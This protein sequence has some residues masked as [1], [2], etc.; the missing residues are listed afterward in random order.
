MA[1][2]VNPYQKRP[3]LAAQVARKSVQMG[4][5]SQ[6]RLT[7]QQRTHKLQ[8]SSHKK[9][10]GDQLTLFGGQVF[11]PVKHCVV[12]KAKAIGAAVPHRGHDQR[13]PMNRKTKGITNPQV[14][15][16]QQQDQKLKAHFAAPSK[17]TEKMSSNN[18]TT[19]S[20]QQF[21]AKRPA[22]NLAAPSGT[23]T[24]NCSNISNDNNAN[25]LVTPEDLC[26]G[27]TATLE[28]SDFCK[29][30]GRFRAP[31][32]MSAIAAIVVD[33]VINSKK[34]NQF[35]DCFDG[36]TTVVPASENM[37]SSPGCHSIVG[38][39]LLLVDWKR[40]FG[41]DVV[42]PH[43]Q[44]EYLKTTRTN[45][46]R[47]KILFPVFG[48]SGPPAW[49]MVQHYKCPSASCKAAFAANDGIILCNLPAYAAASYPVESKYALSK[50]SHVARS[51]TDVFD[52][53]MTTCGN[54][55]LCS[56]LLYN[57]VNRAYMERVT[58]CCSYNSMK[59]QNDKSA[60][61]H[62][63]KEGE[64]ISTHPP[65]GDLIRDAYDEAS[66]SPFTRWKISDHDRHTREIQ[67]VGCRLSCA[68][69]HTH[70]V[71]KNCYGRSRIGATALWDIGT[72]TGEIASAVLVPTTATADL[73]HAA[74]QVTRRPNFNPSAICSDRWPTKEDYWAVLL[75]KEVTGRLGLFHFIK[76]ILRT[77][78]KRHI[79]YYRALN[80]LLDAICYY[81]Q[82]DYDQL[83]GALKAGTIGGG[84]KHTD[85]DIADL[86]MTKHFRKRYGKHL[87]K[88]IRPA[89]V[90]CE[91]LN[92]WFVQ[93]KVTASEGA[94]PPLGRTDPITNEP[95]FTQDTKPAVDNCKLKAQHLQDPLP[96]QQMHSAIE[97]VENSAHGLTQHASHRGESNL[98][99]FHLMLAH[100][101][102]NGM[103]ESLADNLNLTG[104][105]RHNLSIRHKM[106]LMTDETTIRQRSKMPSAWEDVVSYCNHSELIYVNEL[107]KEA[108]YQEVPFPVVESLVPDTGERFFSECL[109][110]IKNQRPPHDEQDLCLCH[111]CYG[112]RPVS[113][114]NKKHAPAV[115]NTT[116]TINNDSNISNVPNPWPPPANVRPPIP[117]PIPIAALPFIWTH[118]PDLHTTFLLGAAKPTGHIALD[119]SRG[120]AHLMTSSV[121]I[122]AK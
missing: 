26:E 98:E 95:L 46:S 14:L 52:L 77:I 118:P 61:K 68:E 8:A 117:V 22:K 19:D 90:I 25:T 65:A 121:P 21:F 109:C 83:L 78:R 10:K 93:F 75:G 107:A 18:T 100:F 114:V 44:K 101:G 119:W 63:E 50:H 55:D 12:C 86:K 4:P 81:N 40:C 82:H 72:D 32:A 57:G 16:Q 48:L 69:D 84:S 31:L 122:E 5:Q 79:D 28:D 56:R 71:T 33:K 76:R 23:S 99:A 106:R 74:I 67:G 105:A 1:P 7:L 49:C 35:A 111:K 17:E 53:I 20:V 62:I 39:C 24:T 108:G 104:A 9:R 15:Q 89:N 36:L 85:E 94:R 58:D 34:S 88:H 102:N 2:P 116:T 54:G 115:E 120:G 66:S 51:A 87:R 43:C 38:Q 47:N 42:C 113:V 41:L 60:P 70:E 59:G 11:D 3:P 6:Q 92:D 96:L 73:S 30:H 97:P 103:R 112:E 13:C 29:T 45:F 91:R 37:Y 64:F 80:L 27:V 110:W